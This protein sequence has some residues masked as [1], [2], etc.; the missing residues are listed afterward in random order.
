MSYYIDL[1]YLKIVSCRLEGF[2]QKNQDLFNFRCPFCGDST[3]KKSKKRGFAYRKNNDLFYKCFND[4]SCGT[5]FYNFLDRIDSNLAKEYALERFRD[6]ETKNHNYTKPKFDFKK[7]TFKKK[8]KFLIPSIK[9]LDDDNIAKEYVLSRK[10]P[11]GHFK[12]L[13]YA[14]DFKKFVLQ[15]KPDYDKV[16]IDND[17]RL[18]IPFKDKDGNVFAF[19]GRSLNGS[20]LRYITVKLNEDETKIFGLDR[21][22]RNAKIFVTEGPIDSLFLENAIATA[23][24]NLEIAEFLGKDNIVLVYDNEPRNPQIVKNIKRS[25]DNGFNICLFPPS[26]KGKDINEAVLNGMSKP[27]IRRMIDSHTYSG[28]RAQVEFNNWK[29]C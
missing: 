28:L 20:K 7:P 25:I 22:N 9:E 3:K 2:T 21:L 19:Q 11:K 8:E 14:E 18:I 16:L 10:I 5:T 27:E 13:F 29:K 15:I 24:S 23:D 26:F 4:E 6:G 1:K 12:D 17:P